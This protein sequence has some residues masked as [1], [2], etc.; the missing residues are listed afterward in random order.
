MDIRYYF[1]SYRNPRRREAIL[2]RFT[3]EGIDIEEIPCAEHDEPRVKE[4]SNNMKANSIF[5]SQLNEIESFYASGADYGVFCED[6]ILIKKG[7]RAYISLVAQ[8]M[9]ENKY[10]VVLLGYLLNFNIIGVQTYEKYKYSDGVFFLTPPEDLWGAQMYILSKNHAGKL[11][12]EIKDIDKCKE[13][14]NIIATDWVMTKSGNYKI[15]YP[16]LAIEDCVDKIDHAGQQAF[17][18]ACH[19][20]FMNDTFH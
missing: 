10:D 14:Y 9:K 8:K 4:L 15:I 1:T 12:E 18:E 11:L 6:D 7:L 5:Y 13:K 3:K 20:F 17:H 2:E 19:R 16:P